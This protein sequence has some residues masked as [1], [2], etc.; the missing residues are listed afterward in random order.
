MKNQRIVILLALFSLLAVP[1]FG[2]EV[3]TNGIDTWVTPEN[4]SSFL[5]F[6]NT[7]IP[8]GF[9]CRG[10]EPFFGRVEWRGAP[11][12]SEP[13]GALGEADTIVQRLD[14][15]IFDRTG[16]ATTRLQ[17][18]A[19]ALRSMEPIR[20]S[21]GLFDVSASLHGPQAITEMQISRTKAGG[22]LFDAVLGVNTRLT[23]TPVRQHKAARTLTLDR[24]FELV[25]R[26]VKWQSERPEKHLGGQIGGFVLVDTDDDGEADTFLPGQSDFYA[27]GSVGTK[28][29]SVCIPPSGEI[30]HESSEPGHCHCTVNGEYPFDAAEIN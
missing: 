29:G 30:C 20:T 10:S 1:A 18:R 15:V 6:S 9:F 11:L 3:I 26:S 14:D 28:L 21:C 23:F 27:T 5:D 7:P 8:A 24:E 12:A 4:G 19:L 2:D 22:G 16:K 25:T 17:V 13:E